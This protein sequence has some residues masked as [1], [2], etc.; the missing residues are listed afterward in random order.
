MCS[1]QRRYQRVLDDTGPAGSVHLRGDQRLRALALRAAQ[2]PM[3]L[4]Q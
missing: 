1:L 4:E 2:N 3:R